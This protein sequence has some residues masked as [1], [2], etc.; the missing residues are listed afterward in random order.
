MG[1]RL[2]YLQLV[3]HELEVYLVALKLF[4]VDNL[5][6][7]YEAAL[8]MI[9]FLDFSK[10]TASQDLIHL[11]VLVNVSHMLEAL[12]VLKCELLFHLLKI[13]TIGNAGISS[14]SIA[15]AGTCRSVFVVTD[16]I[17][18]LSVFVA[19]RTHI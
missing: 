2:E 14:A 7:T 9:C 16:S 15:G 5:D 19:A 12:E 8:H 10:S 4:L 3:L 11:V 18:R 6:S 1:S 17:E 13:S